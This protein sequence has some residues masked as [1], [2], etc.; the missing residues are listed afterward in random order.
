[1]QLGCVSVVARP[2]KTCS[3]ITWVG[4]LLITDASN[5]R[6]TAFRCFQMLLSFEDYL[7]RFYV[8]YL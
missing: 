2:D 7:C 8:N 1:M 3:E 5:I 4:N 6:I